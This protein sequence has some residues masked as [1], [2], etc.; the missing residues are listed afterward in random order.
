MKKILIAF[1]FCFYGVALY[2]QELADTLTIFFRKESSVFDAGYRSNGASLENFCKRIEGYIDSAAD[3]DIEICGAA[4]PEG[5]FEYNRM[6]SASRTNALR[7]V[8]SDRLSIPED[9]IRCMS[10]SEDWDVL[11]QEIESDTT[12]RHKS[13]ILDIIAAKG[14]SGDEFISDLMSIDNAR[15]YWY[16][17][18][19]IY[20]EIRACRI[21]ATVDFSR[22]IE[23][24]IDCDSI[25]VEDVAL[26][27]EPLQPV[28][29]VVSVQP[30][31][32][33]RTLH[34]GGVSTS[35]T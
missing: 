8:L 28:D 32:V 35:I 10:V 15:T 17:Y 9:R 12:L 21:K 14:G 24:T 25:V 7:G 27:C 3:V 5:D 30:I 34:S 6:I 29:P 4:S 22:A 18:H 11:V 2:G 26:S 1:I 13:R 20:P 23:T 19:N 31:E 33:P 16:I